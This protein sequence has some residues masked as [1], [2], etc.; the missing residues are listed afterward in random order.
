MAT[1]HA[2]SKL[3]QSVQK[4]I[5]VL[6]ATA[7]SGEGASVSALARAAGLPR[8]TA[9]RLIQ[10]LQQ[11]G[12][13]LR[14]PQTDRVLLGPELVRLARQVDMGTLLRELAQG[15]LGE[16]SETVRE[17]VTL[18]VV[19]ADGGLD[20][21]YQVAGPHHLIPRS[22]LGRRFP[23]HASSSGKILLSTY[24]DD[25]LERA[26]RHPLAALTPHTITTRCALRDELEQVRAQGYATTV[27]ELEEG[28]AG[29]SVGIFGE[30]GAL[31]GTINVSGLSQRLDEAAQ[32]RTVKHMRDVVED[33]EAVLR[34]PRP[35]AS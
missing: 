34:Q 29:V 3:N 1:S 13:L 26:L 18:S 6:R 21:V 33:I 31:V 32:R 2:G 11:D 5:A 24:D 16:L 10:T 7:A 28:L 27:D 20:L 14:V 15:A 9:L 8:A 23:L 22:W 35:A 12:F 19:A 4:A 17:T 30:T 25:R